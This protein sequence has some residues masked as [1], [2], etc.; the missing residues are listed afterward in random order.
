MPRIRYLKPDFFLDE[1]IGYLT[2]INRLAYAGLWCHADRLG[3]L[4][5]RPRYLKTQLFPYDDVDMEQILADLSRPKTT[6]PHKTFITR[7]EVNGQKY[8]QINKFLDHQKPH[9]TERKS[10][11][12]PPLTVNNKLIDGEYPV[13]KG[14]GKK[15]YGEEKEEGKLKGKGSEEGKTRSTGANDGGNAEGHPPVAPILGKMKMIGTMTGEE[16]LASLRK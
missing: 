6:C 15:I 5:D 9:H 8:I 10:T 13:G 7:Y 3:R 4:E 12:P 2:V 16:L 1:D 11:I 14:M